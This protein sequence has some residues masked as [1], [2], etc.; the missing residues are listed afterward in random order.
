[1]AK[2]F[3][4]DSDVLSKVPTHDI[5]LDNHVNDQIVQEMQYSKQPHSNN[6]TDVDITSDSNIILYEQY[7]K[8]TRNSVVQNTNSSTQLDAPIMTVIEDISKQVAKCNE[9]DKVNENANE[10]LTTEL[11]GYKEQIKILEERQK[12]DLNDKE[13]YIDGQL[14]EVIV[15]R[16]AKVTDFQNQI[17]TLKLQLSATVESQKT[18]STMVDV[19]KKESKAKEDKYLK[20]IIKLERKKEG[21]RQCSLQNGLVKDSFNKIRSHIKF[22]EVITVHTK[23]AGQNEGTWRFK[24]IRGAYEKD[25]KPFV[26]TLKEY[27]HMFNQGLEKEINDMKEVFPQMETEVDKCSVERKCFTIKEKELLLE[28][29]RLLGLIISQDLMHTTVN[30]LAIIVD[31]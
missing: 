18:L 24:Y 9:E 17:H 23:V 4:Y 15:D 10:S 31:Y 28:N 26:K 12:F 27:F 14:R 16:N 20:E 29:D 19:L 3:A 7:L 5:Y 21:F 2:L 1:M 13:K 22:D 25:A 8:E 30:S 11:E 6:Q